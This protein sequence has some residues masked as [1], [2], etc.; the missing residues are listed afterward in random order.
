MN[1]NEKTELYEEGIY[2]GITW[3]IGRAELVAETQKKKGDYAR[4][5]GVLGIISELKKM[6][7]A[8]CK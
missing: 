8:I 7:K 4:R 2:Q 3:A 5:L 6:K 1:L